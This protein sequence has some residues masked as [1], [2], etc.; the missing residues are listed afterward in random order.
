MIKSNIELYVP[1]KGYENIYEVSNLGNIRTLDR[2]V[3][4]KNGTT[5]FYKGIY[6]KQS[7]DKDGYSIVKFNK[8]NIRKHKKVHRL[9]AEAFI[10]NPYNLPCINHKDEVKTNNRVENLEWC[11]VKYNNNYGTVKER[12]SK[13]NSKKVYQYDL[14]GNLIKVWDNARIASENG[15]T[16]SSISHCC[17][18]RRKKHKGYIWSYKQL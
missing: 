18:G 10:P 13:S 14:N 2:N 5:H 12:I 1:V 6:K 7:K 4:Y 11:S 17:L 3:I 9:V 15:F 8:N 16:R